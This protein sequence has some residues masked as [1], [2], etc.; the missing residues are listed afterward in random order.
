MWNQ[1]KPPRFPYLGNDDSLYFTQLI[2]TMGD[3]YL[4]GGASMA[5][6]V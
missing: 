1:L 5:G 4:D 6:H 2:P 3:A